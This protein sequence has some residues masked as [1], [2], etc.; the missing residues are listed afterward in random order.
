[1]A[2]FTATSP[3]GT[4]SPTG[5]PWPQMPVAVGPGGVPNQNMTPFQAAYQAYQMFQDPTLRP[6]DSFYQQQYQNL[7]LHNIPGSSPGPTIGNLP[8]QYARQLFNP[9]SNL[10]GQQQLQQYGQSAIES[11]EAMNQLGNIG[12]GINYYMNAWPAIVGSELAN[13][14]PGMFPQGIPA[15]YNPSM[16]IGPRNVSPGAPGTGYDYGYE[17]APGGW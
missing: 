4:T 9:F 13:T 6:P 15:P 7:P 2:Q 1:M 14:I 11:V 12:A 17:F 3:T 5:A 8:A 16:P 10:P